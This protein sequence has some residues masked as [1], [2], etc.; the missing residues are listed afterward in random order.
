MYHYEF[1]NLSDLD[2]V[3]FKIKLPKLNGGQW[4]R[5]IHYHLIEEIMIQ[6]FCKEILLDKSA[7]YPEERIIYDELYNKNTRIDDPLGSE[8]LVISYHLLPV[9]A[10]KRYDYLQNS[11]MPYKI[12]CDIKINDNPKLEYLCIPYRKEE[13]SCPNIE[14]SI[15]IHIIIEKDD[16]LIVDID[17]IDEY[18]MVPIYI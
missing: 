13:F 14:G 3:L 8:E 18:D 5:H 7:Y 6:V 9:S 10:E 15:D 1:D 17:N 16:V 12:T 11:C 4:I 2:K